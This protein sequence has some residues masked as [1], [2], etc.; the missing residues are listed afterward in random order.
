ME[1][2][3][4]LLRVREAE[5]A[6]EAALA[7]HH[8][9]CRRAGVRPVF[10][11][12]GE[13]LAVLRHPAEDLQRDLGEHAEGALAAHHDLV[14]IRTG[15]LAGIVAGL[16]HAAGRGVFLREDN[17]GDRAVIGA[18]L[19]R[20]AR[21]DPAAHGA[22]FKALREVA[23]GILTL[24]SEQLRRI[25]ERRLQIRAGHARLHGDGLVDLVEGEDL[26]EVAAHVETH[27]ALGRLHAARDGGAAAVNIERD[28]MRG[29]IGD[30]LL[31]LLGRLGIDDEIRQ[32]LKVAV[33]HAQ[34]VDHRLAIGNGKAVVVRLGDVLRSDDGGDGV[35]VR[36]VELR[37]VLGAEVDRVETEVVVILREILVL[38][39][40]AFLAVFIQ[41]LLRELEEVRVAP[42]KNGAVAVFGGAVGKPLRLK[43]LVRFLAH[44]VNS[45]SV[46]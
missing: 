42:A 32:A 34:K 3:A 16:D 2:Q 13:A 11:H 5:D 29:D 41:A 33:A 17:V 27:A 31:D 24:G 20:A 12:V 44:D 38:Q 46:A 26:L 21:D 15:G 10:E 14:E 37:R 6:G 30:D 35:H 8:F 36:R 18:V 1:H 23:A 4:R 45:F 22:V 40:A 25:L 19:P 43:A 39:I 7:L 9:L 28:L